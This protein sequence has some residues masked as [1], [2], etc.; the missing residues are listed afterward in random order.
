MSPT[1][2]NKLQDAGFQFAGDWQL[3]GEKIKLNFLPDK[4]RA[5]VYV[6]VLDGVIVY[7]GKTEYC[8]RQRLNGYRNPG[9][10]Q[11]TNIRVKKLIL[12][13]LQAGSRVQVLFLSPDPTE[14]KDLPVNTAVGLE[15]GL[16]AL[17]NPKWN[18]LN[19]AKAVVEDLFAG[20]GK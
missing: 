13:A 10:T 14:W 2:L 7:I 3:D 12:L 17:L 15:S 11:R 4:G 5:S 6:Y 9:P 8:L 19:T 18:M 20:V 16:I 1:M